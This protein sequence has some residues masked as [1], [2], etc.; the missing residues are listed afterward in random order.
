[1]LGL[2]LDLKEDSGLMFHMFDGV[3]ER[4]SI[5]R[6]LVVVIF[7]GGRSSVELT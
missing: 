1:M 3:P 7:I 4:I 6:D 5:L 2:L